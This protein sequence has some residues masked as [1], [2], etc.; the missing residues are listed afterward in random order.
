MKI[1]LWDEVF[2]LGN[3]G[4]LLFT[5]HLDEALLPGFSMEDARGRVHRVS[6]A[7]AQEDWFALLVENGDAAYFERLFR[8]V[9][10]DALK[11]EVLSAC[12]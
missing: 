2:P 11:M 6:R 12:L 7:E 10:V 3:Q 4:V 8:D 5:D 1:Q 9:R